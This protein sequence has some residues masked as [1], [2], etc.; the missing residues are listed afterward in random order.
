MPSNKILLTDMTWPEAAEARD[1]DAVVLLPLAS[2]EP[3]GRHS[4]MGGE[5]H[6]VE[7]FCERVATETGALVMPTIPYGYAPSFMAFPGTVT[8]EPNTFADVVYDSVASMLKHGFTRV[9]IINN[10]SG[11]NALVAEVAERVRQTFGRIVA[12]IP[13]P[14]V[15]K[16]I[17]QT[18]HPDAMKLHGHG[19]EPGVSIRTYLTPEAMRPDLYEPHEPIRHNGLT[20]AGSNVKTAGVTW[21]FYLNYHETNVHG[22]SGDGSHPSAELGKQI[23]EEMIAAGVEIVRTFSTLETTLPGAK[24]V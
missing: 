7:A 18:N 24:H 10:H 20:F 15:M 6:I 12:S 14:S 16:E 4:V 19:G 17:T 2:V 9:L 22:G 11:N 3:S 8:L 23:L 1:R 21:N 13:L 5:Q